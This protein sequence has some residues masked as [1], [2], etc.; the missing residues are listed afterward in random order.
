MDPTTVVTILALNLVAIGMLLSMISREMADPQGVRGFATG[1]VVFGLAYLL[2]LASGHQT[3]HAF[4]VVADAAMVFAV[5]CFVTGMRYF[6]GLAPVGRRRIFI[7]VA[8]FAVAWGVAFALWQ[9]RGRHVMLNGA[10]AGL[11]LLLAYQS[12]SAMGREAGKLRMP[13]GTLGMA[14]GLLGLATGIRAL[15][16]PWAGVEPLFV[17]GPA[18]LYYGF[19]TLVTVIMGPN[20]LWLV[21]SRLNDRLATLATRDPLTGLLN[22]RGLDE[23]LHR[24]FG[25]R[26][27][28]GLFLLQ[29]DIDFFKRINDRHGHTAGDEVL[30]GVAQTLIE[31]IRPTDFAAR[32]GGE[33]FLVGCHGTDVAQ[34]TR[35]AERL[36]QAIA[37]QAHDIGGAEVVRCTVSIGVSQALMARE[38]WEQAMRDADR[39]LYAAKQAGRNRVVV[40][41]AA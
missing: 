21:F 8:C 30:R 23:A 34:V 31:Q 4:S 36:R 22:R 12:L 5:L 1:A 26:P 25:A 32:L 40:A 10:L 18:Q 33:E 15:T 3:T 20:L 11:Y 37:D 2:R 28:H 19:A 17:G 7:G 35:L 38:M 9:D 39:S 16:V 13:L 14:T 29:A 6:S 24:H 41:A 27:P